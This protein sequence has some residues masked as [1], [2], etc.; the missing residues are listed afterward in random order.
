M[1]WRRVWRLIKKE[2]IQVLRDHKM[3]GILIVAPVVQLFIFGYAVST[4]VNSI[5]TAILDEDATLA[6]REL[7]EALKGSGYF[8][9]GEELRRSSDIDDRLQR[10]IVQMVLHIPRGFAEDLAE[11]RPAQLQTILDATDSM[12]ARI[13]GGYVNEI[14]ARFSAAR[15][16]ERYE[17]L[18]AT[19]P[20]MPS[21]EARIRV[22]YNPELKSVNFMIPGVLCMI[23]LII[24]LMMTALAIVKEK[25]IGT[26]EALIVTPIKPWEL[27][28]GK[29]L[30]F[31]LFSLIDTALI[32][33]VAAFWFQVVP[34]G[35]ILLLFLM[36][37]LFIMTGLGLGIF[38]STV[39]NTQQE[40]V[41]VSFFLL[42]P[43]ILLSGF[44]FPIEN[45]PNAIQAITYFIPLRYFLVAIRGIFLKGNG[46]AILWPQALA[47]LVFAITIIGLAAH[48][49]K[50]RLG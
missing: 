20:R 44:M 19:I 48:R 8:I 45:M 29:T 22:W 40:A 14:V 50:K 43:S 18:R 46:I 38:I 17:K 5:A 3:L 4:D 1:N 49:F 33:I 28:V 15:A 24:T 47:L 39:S 2:L 30:P 36:A 42:L 26:L 25:E 35:S 13:I 27:M 9:I 34:A 10:G 6:S 41:M 16:S 11:N 37:V 12:T 31:L 7:V 23:L 32:L 21:I